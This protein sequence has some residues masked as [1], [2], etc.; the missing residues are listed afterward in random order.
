MKKKTRSLTLPLTATVAAC[1]L[2]WPWPGR[3]VTT[4]FFDASQTTNF[5]AAGATSDTLS[6]EGY[7]FTYTRDK[8]FTGGVGMT[9]PIGRY[10]R[11]SWPEGLEAQAVTAGPNPG[12]AKLIISRQDGQPFDLPAF[13]FK[14]LANTAG[15]GAAMEVMPKLN[16]E[17]A[18]PDPFMYD[19][20]GYYGQNFT[21]PGSLL[22]GGDAYIFSLYVDFALTGFTAVDASLPVVIG[23]P[24]LVMAAPAADTLVCAWP[25]NATG[26]V[27]QHNRDL[28]PNHWS[29]VTNPVSVVGTNHQVTISPLVGN[30]FFRLMHP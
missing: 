30:G 1:V 2:G 10:V 14:L 26:F 22:T 13:S 28:N 20:T 16:G 15:A 25:T 18:R 23:P 11:V 24:R 3:G 4:V 9:N 17:D 7:L 27:L 12:G 6:S 19:A 29:A 5:I 8:L 21:Y